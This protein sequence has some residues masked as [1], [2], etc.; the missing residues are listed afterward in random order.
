MGW[1]H[2][3]LQSAAIG[4]FF[5][6]RVNKCDQLNCRSISNSTDFP[7][8]AATVLWHWKLQPPALPAKASQSEGAELDA[9]FRPGPATCRKPDRSATW[10]A[11]GNVSVIPKPSHRIIWV[12]QTRWDGGAVSGSSSSLKLVSLLK[13]QLAV[14]QLSQCHPGK[15]ALVKSDAA[16]KWGVVTGACKQAV[17]SSASQ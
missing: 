17:H 2:K 4:K 9:D 7:P 15:L 5:K 13:C 6:H 1:F 8:I 3:L 12:W 11:A 14:R 10:W 16:S